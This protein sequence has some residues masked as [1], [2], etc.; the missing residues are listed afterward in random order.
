MNADGA[1]GGAAPEKPPVAALLTLVVAL[2]VAVVAWRLFGKAADAGV[3]R[4][5]RIDVVRAWCAEFYAQA[6]TSNDTM[7]VDRVALPDTIDPASSDA[8]DRCGDLRE[9][10][11]QSA[12]SNSREMTGKEMP[13]GLR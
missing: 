10:I 11:V 9:Q 7:R 3:E 8:I 4:L 5:A 12:P 13:R 2:V 1:S 6:R